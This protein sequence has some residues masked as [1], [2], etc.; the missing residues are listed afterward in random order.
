VRSDDQEGFDG[1]DVDANTRRVESAK[2]VMNTGAKTSMGAKDRNACEAEWQEN[3]Q[4]QTGLAG[5]AFEMQNEE[6]KPT[7]EEGT[8]LCV[9][10]DDYPI[11][12]PSQSGRSCSEFA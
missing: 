7:G 3:F 6:A 5:I 11:H 1:C 12:S 10:V 4:E 8:L 9:Y 2:L